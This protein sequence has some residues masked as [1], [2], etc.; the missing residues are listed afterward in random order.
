[1]AKVKKCKLQKLFRQIFTLTFVNNFFDVILI[2]ARNFGSEMIKR[3]L[4]ELKQHAPFTFLGALSG[5]L[6]FILLKNIPYK[7]SYGLFYTF[8]PLHVFLSAYVTTSMYKLHKEKPDMVKLCLIGFFGS[9]GIATLS[10]SIIPYIG[11]F[12]LNMPEREIH[13]GFIEKWYFVNPVA[14]LGIISALFVSKTKF[15]HMGHVFVSTWA[16]LFHIMMSGVNAEAGISLYFWIL[17]LLFFSVW[18]P[19]CFSDIVFPLLF[20]KGHDKD[21]PCKSKSSL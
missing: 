11:E 3:V 5:I 9:V 8:H 17:I 6:I 21:C 16:S 7:I 10:D 4:I 18:I 19:C 14:I 13:L 1:M 20:I 15:P 12:L 2:F